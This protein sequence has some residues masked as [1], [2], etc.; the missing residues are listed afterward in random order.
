MELMRRRW[1]RECIACGGNG[2]ETRHSVSNDN[3]LETEFFCDEKFQGYDNRVHGGVIATLMDSAMTNCLFA[4]GI[5]AV[6]GELKIR[7]LKPVWPTRKVTIQARIASHKSPLFILEAQMYQD[8]ILTCRA[9]A[10][11][12]KIS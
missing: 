2:L 11:F 7:Y 8:G 1:H 4:A 5:A 12:M 9:H 3:C 10:R 6:T